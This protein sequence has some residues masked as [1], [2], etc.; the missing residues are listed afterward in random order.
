MGADVYLFPLS[1][2]RRVF[3][4][5][6]DGSEYVGQVWPGFTVSFEPATGLPAMSFDPAKLSLRCFPIGSSAT[7]SGGG[8][9]PYVIGVPAGLSFQGYG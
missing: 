8:Q 6:P 5:N 3:I 1:V 4:T 9:T 7:P 2:F